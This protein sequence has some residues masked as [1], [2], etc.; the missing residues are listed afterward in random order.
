MFCGAPDLLQD[1]GSFPLGSQRASIL[2]LT[3]RMGASPAPLGT[4]GANGMLRP[5]ADN[6]GGMLVR[7]VAFT[8]D[9]CTMS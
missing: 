2:Q 1:A 3:S 6:H 5:A 4:K 7:H 8:L 9:V